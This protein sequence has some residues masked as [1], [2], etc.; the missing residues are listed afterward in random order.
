MNSDKVDEVS[1]FVI[2]HLRNVEYYVKARHDPVGGL[3]LAAGC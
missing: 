1:L 2:C 3:L